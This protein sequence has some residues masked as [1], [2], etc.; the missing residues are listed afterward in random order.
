[1]NSTVAGID[2]PHIIATTKDAMMSMLKIA[3]RSGV[4]FVLSFSKAALD[5]TMKTNINAAI[6]HSIQNSD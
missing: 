6:L 3:R 5:A 1:M 4:R 2:F